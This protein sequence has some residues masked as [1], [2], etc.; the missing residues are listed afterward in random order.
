L[1]VEEPPDQVPVHV[2]GNAPK[3]AHQETEGE[4]TFGVKFVILVWIFPGEIIEALVDS[5]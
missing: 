5:A 1:D 2:H 4:T 3:V